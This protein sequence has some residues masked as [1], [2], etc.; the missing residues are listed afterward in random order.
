MVTQLI[1]V[2]L[3]QTISTKNVG[4]SWNESF[5]GVDGVTGPDESLFY[6]DTNQN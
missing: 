1:V 6:F 4:L 5:S 3:A 2:K